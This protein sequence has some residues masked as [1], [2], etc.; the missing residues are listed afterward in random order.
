MPYKVARLF[1]RAADESTVVTPYSPQNL[2][3]PEF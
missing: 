1:T 2:V 3:F